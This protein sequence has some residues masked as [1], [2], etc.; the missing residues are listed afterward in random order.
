MFLAASRCS[1]EM[2]LSSDE[3]M[4]IVA[5]RDLTG[6]GI[7]EIERLRA[8]VAELKRFAH[9]TEPTAA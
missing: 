5:V 4:P 6:G 1:G 3:G 8:E 7:A 9:A 2:K